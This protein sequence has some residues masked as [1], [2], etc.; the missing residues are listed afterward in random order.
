MSNSKKCI[1][2]QEIMKMNEKMEAEIPELLCITDLPRFHAVCLNVW[3][4]QTAHYRYIAYR[5]L[6]R[7][8]MGWLGRH[9]RVV[10]LA[11][12]VNK[13]GETLP[14]QTMLI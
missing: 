6:T 3:T 12:A 7:W 11:C 13:I 8:V 9:I 14:L 4:L 10:L 5:Q 1:C 2:C